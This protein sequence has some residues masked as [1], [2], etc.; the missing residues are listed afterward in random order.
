MLVCKEIL[1]LKSLM[2]FD[3][4]NQ[5]LFLRDFEIFVIIFHIFFVRKCRERYV[6]FYGNSKIENNGVI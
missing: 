5:K 4:I 3:K 6:S 2:R 1:K